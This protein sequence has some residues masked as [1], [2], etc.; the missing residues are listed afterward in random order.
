MTDS[1][2][3]AGFE[4]MP[5]T[6]ALLLRSTE[7]AVIGVGKLGEFHLRTGLYIYVGSALGP[8]GVRGRLAHHMRSAEHPHWHI[9]YLRYHT[10][11]D[12]IWCCYCRESLEH[13]WAEHF[14]GF[15][16][17]SIPLAGFGSSDCDC[18]SHLFFFKKRPATLK[19]IGLESL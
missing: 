13:A 8:G 11:L 4:P 5:G 10:S 9:D 19:P 15:K 18:V 17:G 3:L 2:P 6:Y 14:A 16:G 7:D 1:T 12:E